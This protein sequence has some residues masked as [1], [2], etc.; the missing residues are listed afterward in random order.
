MDDETLGQLWAL[1]EVNK[2]LI[3]GL[4]TAIFVMENWD[5]L[6]E[7]RRT[8]MITSVKGLVAQS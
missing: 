5:D 8:S 4:N 3:L 1:R 2:G 7:E 6:T